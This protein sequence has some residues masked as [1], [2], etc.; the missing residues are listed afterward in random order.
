MNLTQI[1]LKG[2]GKVKVRS[3]LNRW[4]KNEINSSLEYGVSF[5][6]SSVIW[7]ENYTNLKEYQIEILDGEPMEVDDLFEFI[8][9]KI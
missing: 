1:L 8:G 7:L 9:N 5:D 4:I 6:F 2:L 3:I